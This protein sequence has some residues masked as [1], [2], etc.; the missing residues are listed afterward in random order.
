[1]ADDQAGFQVDENG[2]LVFAR[3]AVDGIPELEQIGQ[4]PL[5]LFDAA[6]YAG[7]AGDDA[8]A[9]RDVQLVHG[10]AQFLAVFAFDPARD[11]AAPGVVGHQ[12]QVAPR[13]RDE[14]GQGGALVAALFL[15]DLNDE[16]LA[17]GEGVLD[18]RRAHIDAFLE[19]AAGDF[20]EGQ[21]AVAF[22]AVADEAG[23]EAGLYAGDDPFVDV[24]F[25]L[26]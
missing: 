7:R 12:D 18:A 2:R 15:F 8:H 10:F 6:A 17:F 5:E 19:V 20:L 24:A 25:A 9:G 13:Q 14:G 11:A 1:G 23:F 21:E 4:V 3:R 22:F 16:F 26:F